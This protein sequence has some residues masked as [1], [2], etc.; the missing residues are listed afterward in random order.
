MPVRVG[1]APA[2]APAAAPAHGG[3]ETGHIVTVSVGELTAPFL[4]YGLE[5]KLRTLDGVTSVK[6]HTMR[7]AVEVRYKDEA[8]FDRDTLEETVEAAGFKTK[9]VRV[10]K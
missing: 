4:A 2:P 1:V 9:R 3:E 6:L 7:G 8:S 10:K 5:K